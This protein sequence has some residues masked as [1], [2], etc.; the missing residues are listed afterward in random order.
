MS[1]KPF[2]QP[3]AFVL[4]LALLAAAPSAQAQ[5]TC[6][7]GFAPI[8]PG[9]FI[10]GGTVANTPA[11][12]LPR[13][14]VTLSEG[15]CIS[16]TEVTRAQW[17]AAMGTTPWLKGDGTPR[18]GVFMPPG[19]QPDAGGQYPAQYISWEDAQNYIA[20]LNQAEEADYYRLPTEAEWEYACRAGTQLSF[21]TDPQGT[22]ITEQNFGN[23]AWYAVNTVNAGEDYPHEVGQK[24]ANAW[25][26]FDLFGNVWEWCS[27]WYDPA[28]Y[29]ASPAADPQGPARSDEAT[30][31]LRG[32][33]FQEFPVNPGLEDCRAPNRH[34]AL[35][36]V[37]L[38]QAGFRLVWVE[39]PPARPPVQA[40]DGSGGGCFLGTSRTQPNF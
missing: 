26:L 16:T 2:F 5:E 40:K 27:D 22:E 31:V 38:P 13:H 15:F 3:F 14:T 4:F 36:Q 24:A 20:R 19:G 1:S 25:E 39:N 18:D 23:F 8:T 35:A 37:R 32:G 12:E 33:S 34:R 10:M 28:Y 6:P 11:D 21:S 7:A 29:A 30:R 9:Q 17:I